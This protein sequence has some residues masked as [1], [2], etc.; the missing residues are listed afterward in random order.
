MDRKYDR[1]MWI[2]VL[3][4][5]CDVLG[6]GLAFIGI[7]K[8]KPETTKLGL[9]FCAASALA[10]FIGVVIYECT[11]AAAAEEETKRTIAPAART[12]LLT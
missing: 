6:V 5:T 2:I 9:W 12:N 3:T 8:D 10:Q 7:D 1:L 11:K 4:C